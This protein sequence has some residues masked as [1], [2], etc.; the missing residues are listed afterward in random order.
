[1]ARTWC[2]LP[3]VGKTMLLV[4]VAAVLHQFTRFFDRTFKE[5]KFIW[6]DQVA[7]GC[8]YSTAEWVSID[9]IE[10]ARQI[11]RQIG[12]RLSK[13]MAVM[14]LECCVNRLNN[15]TLPSKA[16]QNSRSLALQVACNVD[17]LK[18][19]TT[20]FVRRGTSERK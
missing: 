20:C 13:Y 10:L 12:A 5:I 6:R 16:T 11:E 2:T 18:V 3:R 7:S 14:A 19:L 1:M 15:G 4:L 9:A 17:P 8:E